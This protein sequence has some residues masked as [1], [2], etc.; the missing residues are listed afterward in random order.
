MWG[1]PEASLETSIGDRGIYR[2]MASGGLVGSREVRPGKE[3]PVRS[4][5][6]KKFPPWSAGLTPVGAPGVSR[7]FLLLL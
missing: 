2:E 1:P 7:R 5:L 3:Q 6:I 4:N